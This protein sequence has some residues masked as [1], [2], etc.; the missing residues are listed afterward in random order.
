MTEHA[1]IRVT[2]HSEKHV[3]PDTVRLTLAVERTDHDHAA[4]LRATED[5]A[6]AVKD[7]LLRAG[8]REEDVRALGL[9]CEPRYETATDENGIRTRIFA[10]YTASRR[11]RAQFAA[12]PA[13]LGSVLEA[14][15][16][17]GAAPEASTEYLFAGY[18][19]LRDELVACAVKDA[20]QRAKTIAKAAGVKLKRVLHA[21]YGGH[22]MPVVRAAALRMNAAELAPEDV[23]LTEDVTVTYEIE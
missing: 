20:K 3:R 6:Q 2:G 7:A 22:G 5:A 18:D 10:G 11:I 1:T 17:S 16:A 14:L 19:A 23:A 8:V 9:R 13:A 12:D 4:A 15:S 21:E